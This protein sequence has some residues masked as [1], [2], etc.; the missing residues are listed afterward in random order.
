PLS[1]PAAHALRADRIG[2][3]ESGADAARVRDRDVAPVAAD[4]ALASDRE[5]GDGGDPGVALDEGLCAGF[6]ATTAHALRVDP[7]R[8]APLAADRV[9]GRARARDSGQTGLDRAP[10][11]DLDG[12]AIAAE[13]APTAEREE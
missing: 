13:L 10:V 6:A 4:A 12:A 1:A 2:V 3:L 7:R 11:R 9:R 5:R 8:A